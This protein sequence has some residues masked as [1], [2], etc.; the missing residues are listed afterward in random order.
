MQ[1]MGDDGSCEGEHE[2]GEFPGEHVTPRSR[3][4]ADEWI[5]GRQSGATQT[6]AI[7]EV[8]RFK[9]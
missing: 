1:H 6:K 7:N 8:D 3:L 4:M 5:D 9:T 2:V